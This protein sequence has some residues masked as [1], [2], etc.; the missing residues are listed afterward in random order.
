VLRTVHPYDD[1]V[2]A[3]S[4]VDLPPSGDGELE[5]DLFDGVRDLANRA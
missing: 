2:L 3:R 4:L 5:T 1:Y